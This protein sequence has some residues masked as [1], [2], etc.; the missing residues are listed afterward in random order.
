[1]RPVLPLL[2]FASALPACSCSKTGADTPTPVTL[3]F[4]NTSNTSVYID[5]SDSDWG[6]VVA[7]S[8]SSETAAP[9]LETLPIACSCLACEQICSAAGCPGRTCP[10]QQ[11]T[12]PL[13]ERLAPGGAV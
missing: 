11:P 10:P 6:L 13:V 2:L 4:T 5:A 12:N 9:Y 7:A 1:M 3:R 8:G